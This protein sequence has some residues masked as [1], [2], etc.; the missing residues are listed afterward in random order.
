[1]DIGL[2]ILVIILYWDSG[3]RLLAS[4]MLG[5]LVLAVLLQA[6]AATRVRYGSSTDIKI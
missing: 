6:A 4:I 3:L 2:D 1:M 5:I